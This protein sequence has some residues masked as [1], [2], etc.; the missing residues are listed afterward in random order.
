MNEVLKKWDLTKIPKE[1]K[2]IQENDEF[3]VLDIETVG[4]KP[5]I[6]GDKQMRGIIEIAAVK[7]KN[8]SIVDDFH[9]FVNP[10]QV[11]PK[12][13]TDLTG[14]T[15]EDVQH[16]PKTTDVLQTFKAF[17]G[18]SVLVAHNASFDIETWLKP[19]MEQAKI[20]FSN[21]YVCT[22]Q[23]FYKSMPG[24]G[25]GAYTNERLASLF[26]F[27]LEDAHRADADVEATA[28]SL[29]GLKKWFDGVDMDALIKQKEE[30]ELSKSD[31][32]VQVKSVNYWRKD[33]SDNKRFIRQYVRIKN[34]AGEGTVFYDLIQKSWG[35]KDFPSEFDLNFRSVE[36]DT[37]AFL[38]LSDI[39]ELEAYRN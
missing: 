23:T 15:N 19:L 5:V 12:N 37:L 7:L 33:F 27:K 30:E 11:I 4:F 1:V 6:G 20:D 35:N 14:I 28:H 38:G 18:A 29:I 3:V 25:K 39:K 10:E 32:P 2:V 17:I 24:L 31:T 9:S 34:D 21:S 13:I 36:R 8:G 22:F 26:G 16:A